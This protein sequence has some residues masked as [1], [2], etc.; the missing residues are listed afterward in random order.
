MQPSIRWLTSISGRCLK[1]NAA[2]DRFIE[3]LHRLGEVRTEE[4]PSALF[5]AASSPTTHSSRPLRDRKAQQMIETGLQSFVRGGRLIFIL[6]MALT[7]LPLA[8]CG[9]RL[10]AD[11]APEFAGKIVQIESIGITGEGTAA[12]IPAFQRAGYSV[13]DLGLAAQTTVKI[14]PPSI[15]YVASVDR[16]GTDGSWWDG[17]FDYSMRVT[18]TTGNR[19][20]WSATAEYGQSGIFI[21]QTKSTEQAMSAM[22][23]NFAKTFPPAPAKTDASEPPTAPTTK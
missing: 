4:L 17:F 10:K 18:D 22:V 1:R 20:V 15:R 9:N 7:C 21:N 19:I 8:A 23:A 3:Y 14:E 12:A 11:V 16:V 2:A 5:S 6:L 13:V